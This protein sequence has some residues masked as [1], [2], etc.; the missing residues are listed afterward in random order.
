MKKIRKMLRFCSISAVV[1]ICWIYFCR[2]VF[3]L[4][5]SFDI[6]NQSSYKVMARYW[7]K[8][9]VFN[10]FH[11]VSLGVSLILIPVLWLVLSHKLYKY[12]FWKF[13]FSPVI[14]IYNHFNRPKNLEVEH[15]SIKNIGGK[16][17]TLDEIISEKIEAQGK[18]TASVHAAKS[19]REQIATK[20]EENEN[21]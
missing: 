5:W 4:F 17:K 6:L 14:K 8:G 16:D 13:I 21:Q 7:E 9:G 11:D 2:I 18:K 19:I 12:G 10:T 3:K 1:L 15:V 20:I